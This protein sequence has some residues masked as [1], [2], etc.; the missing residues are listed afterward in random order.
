MPDEVEAVETSISEASLAAGAR[1]EALEVE[2]TELAD[3]I[4]SG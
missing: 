2:G 4:T 1:G 3:R